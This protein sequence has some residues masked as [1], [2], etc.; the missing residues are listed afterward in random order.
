MSTEQQTTLDF[1]KVSNVQIAGIDHRY[2]PDYS[3]AYIEE[4]DYDGEPM[5]DELLEEL[6]DDR[7]FVYQKVIDHIF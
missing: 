1:S 5:T 2:Y 4:A 6:N 7:D 3:D